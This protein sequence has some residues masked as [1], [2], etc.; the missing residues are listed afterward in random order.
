MRDLIASRLFWKLFLI[1]VG[2]NLAGAVI[3]GLVVDGWMRAEP[4]PSVELR[5]W[6]WGTIAIECSIASIVAY[7]LI[8]RSV[9]PA[10]ALIDAAEALA[11]GDY[12]RSVYVPS[13]DEFG[14][15]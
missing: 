7:W 2:L 12:G 11:T 8:G 3:V 13:R 5:G 9:R 14:K 4:A 10:R 6:L 1:T 15:L